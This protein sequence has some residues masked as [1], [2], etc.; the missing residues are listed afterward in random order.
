MYVG[1]VTGGVVGKT[2]R[3]PAPAGRQQQMPPSLRIGG[4]TDGPTACSG[5]PPPRVVYL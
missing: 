2:A 3:M 1:P 5:P 4:Q